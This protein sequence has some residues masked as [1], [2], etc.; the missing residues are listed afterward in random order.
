MLN[1]IIKS[2]FLILIS[3]FFLFFDNFFWINILLSFFLCF[4]YF[5]SSSY[6]LFF[7]VPLLNI[8]FLLFVNLLSNGNFSYLQN[9][10]ISGFY[11]DTLY[12]EFLFWFVFSIFT[13]NF[14]IT[15]SYKNLEISNYF[16][17]VSLLFII[18]EALISYPHFFKPYT[19]KSDTG[20][21]F[22]ELSCLLFSLSVIYTPKNVF[23]LKYLFLFFF[24]LFVV[25]AIG[26][27]LP[28]SYIIMAY[29]FIASHKFNKLKILCLYTIIFVGGFFLGLLRDSYS[30]NLDV[31]SAFSSTN[32]GAVLYSSSVYIY[33]SDVYLDYT[34][35]LLSFFS[36]FFGTLILPM[37]LLPEVTSINFFVTKFIPIQGN[38]GFISSYS[39][40][41]MSYPGLFLIP[42]LLVFFSK[43]KISSYNYLMFFFLLVTSNRLLLYNIGPI[44]RLLSFLIL[45]LLFFHI[46]VFIYKKLLFK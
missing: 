26:K 24:I 43:L 36:N 25:I 13:Q 6:S 15:K 41:F 8:S 22:F 4:L 17:M 46:F 23:S 14:V 18:F 19:I 12:F 2:F 21:L 35:R 16:Y 3:S 42:M 44:F 29:L 33:F 28:F 45:I 30:G 34:D 32:Q 1:V 7:I 9:A 20:T 5:K 31:F 39:Y 10:K 40:L 37:S 27:R 38:G 11:T